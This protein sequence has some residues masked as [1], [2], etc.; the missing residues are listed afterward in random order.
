MNGEDGY[1]YDTEL[2]AILDDAIAERI[3]VFIDHCYSG[4]FGPDLMSMGNGARV[5]CTTTCTEDGVGYDV[6]SQQNGAWTY[7]F[8]VY[9]WIDNFHSSATTSMESVFNYAHEDFPH[10]NEG[11]DSQQYDG[12]TS[13]AFY[14]A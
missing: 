12:N 14:M 13:T 3:F 4:G 11:N 2:A 1:F 7:Y 8:L 9:G 10:S 6:P 5:Y